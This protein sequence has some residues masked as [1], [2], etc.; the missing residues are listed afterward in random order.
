MQLEERSK[1]LDAPQLDN[2]MVVSLRVRS[3]IVSHSQVQ[4]WGNFY[5]FSAIFKMTTKTVV[6]FGFQ[7]GSHYVFFKKLVS[8]VLKLAKGSNSLHLNSRFLVTRPLESWFHD[9][10]V[11]LEFFVWRDASWFDLIIFVLE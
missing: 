8:G 3:A 1:F 4:M 6:I 9:S 10:Q 7:F 11:F 2:Y 5:L